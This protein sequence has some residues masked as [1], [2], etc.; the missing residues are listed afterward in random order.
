MA[1]NV[2]QHRAPGRGRGRGG[3]GGPAVNPGMMGMGRGGRGGPAGGP[4]MYSGRNGGAG[5]RAGRA[6]PPWVNGGAGRGGGGGRGVPPGMGGGGGVPTMYSGMG[7]GRGRGAVAGQQQRMPQQGQGQG[8]GRGMMGRSGGGRGGRMMMPGSGWGRGGG[9]GRGR[10]KIPSKLDVFNRYIGY[11][12]N[13]FM[14]REDQESLGAAFPQFTPP[15]LTPEQQKM[16]LMRKQYKAMMEQREKNK[17]LSNALKNDAAGGGGGGGAEADAEE[18][19]EDIAEADMLDAPDVTETDTDDNTSEDD[20]ADG[21]NASAEDTPD[22]NNDNDDD[23]DKCLHAKAAEDGKT[24]GSSTG[25]K[26]K[27]ACKLNIDH[28]ED[29]ETVP[30]PDPLCT[31]EICIQALEKANG[32]ESCKCSDCRTKKIENI[33]RCVCDRCNALTVKLADAPGLI[34]KE[35]GGCKCAECTKNE[36]QPEKMKQMMKEREKQIRVN[37]SDCDTLLAALNTKRLY[38]RIKFFK[39]KDPNYDV[40]KAY[41]YHK[42]T[43]EIANVEW[44][45]LI[46]EY[47]SRF[48]KKM[49]EDEI[50]EKEEAERKA[51]NKAKRLKKLKKN[52]KGKFKKKKQAQ[53]ETPDAAAAARDDSIPELKEEGKGDEEEEDNIIN[54][55]SQNGEDDSDGDGDG[56]DEE[57]DSNGDSESDGGNGDRVLDKYEYVGDKPSRYELLMFTP[58]PR[59]VAVLASYPR[60]G[61]SLMR[62]LYEKI[63]LRVTGSDMMGGLQAHD[64]VGEMATSTNQCQFVK[65]HFPERMGSNPF[66]VSRAVLLVRNP[67]D[68]M[69][70]YFNLMTTS[71]HTTSLSNEERKK[72]QPIFAE[73]AKR[74]VLVWRD[75]HEFWLKQKI[76]LLVVRYEDLIRDTV[77]VMRLVIRFVLEINS[78]T[79]FEDRIQR[80]IG[81]EEVESLGPYKARSGGI[82]RSL[83]K[84]SYTPLLL[85]QINHG[86]MGTMEKFGYKEMLVP[87]PKN[88]KLRP[89]DQWGV[90]IAASS[91]Q[92]MIINKDGLVRGP[93]RQTNWRAVKQFIENSR[94]EEE[95]KNKKEAETK[96][97]SDEVQKLDLL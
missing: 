50:K 89:L 91:D 68:S 84:G 67:Y 58:C 38:H 88:W 27:N 97:N 46:E 53:Q 43:E 15:P 95:A 94:K 92:P 65:T 45:A 4:V 24:C 26:P 6:T 93:N 61:N 31:C 48:M 25:E 59:A 72:F 13:G 42:K 17:E 12:I 54:E 8:Q 52:K 63:A 51:K 14:E 81:E 21:R 69:E 73:M 7:H 28:L 96:T 75:F 76:P 85:H 23:D 32:K 1:Q 77:K 57:K 80:A 47:K 33:R 64:L 35:G 2:W 16:L 44:D 55:H 90:Y 79:F 20:S 86:I 29:D 10:S 37:L 71:T 30:L 78:M 60:S 74:E 82:G 11:K 41:P 3:W 66:P 83:T 56:D 22:N 62:N 70:S 19:I 49:K 34:N 5:G 36:T 40:D 18:E 9:R 87:N 39:R